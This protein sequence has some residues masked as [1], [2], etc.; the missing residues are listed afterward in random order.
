DSKTVFESVSDQTDDYLDINFNELGHDSKGDILIPYDC[1]LALSET[2][3]GPV[4][5]DI[6]DLDIQMNTRYCSSDSIVANMLQSINV[7]QYQV[8]LYKSSAI[9]GF[10]EEVF[11][12]NPT[13]DYTDGSPGILPLPAYLFN[14]HQW[15]ILELHGRGF[16]SDHTTATFHFRVVPEEHE[17]CTGG[18]DPP[19]GPGGDKPAGDVAKSLGGNNLQVSPWAENIQLFPNPARDQVTLS[20]TPSRVMRVGQIT[21]LNGQVLRTFNVLPDLKTQVIETSSLEPGV[22]ILTIYEANQLVDHTK[23][24]ILR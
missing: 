18:E 2:Q 24:V 23:L 21:G 9:G 22:Y 15:F 12:T 19:G 7:Q 11:S 17:D 5:T 14:N 1:G 13:G 6:A 3:C 16:C 10:Q 4:C 20:L 8:N